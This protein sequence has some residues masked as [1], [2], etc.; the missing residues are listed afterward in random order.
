MNTLQLS[1]TNAK[2][3]TNDKL[4]QTF[5]NP[6]E[7]HG[8]ISLSNIALWYNWRNV[9]TKLGNTKLTYST[10]VSDASE[11]SEYEIIIPDGSYT[12]SGLN[13]YIH[14]VLEGAG[15][16]D[17]SKSKNDH[18]R[19][20]ISIYENAVYNGI[21]YKIK[22]GYGIVFGVDGL[23]MGLAKTLGG[24][25]N[26]QYQGTD[27]FPNVPQ[28]ENVKSVQIHCNLVYNEYQSDSSLLYNFTPNSTFGSLLSVEPRFPQW[29]QTR[30]TT[31][32]NIEVW[33]TDQDGKSLDVED[34]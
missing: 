32:N 33:L 25:E 13:Y 27:H 20:P 31:E 7:L 15:H 22:T 28:I 19:Y 12:V 5:R 30:N 14:H 17:A 1:T 29:R 2:T 24:V 10:P 9:T 34:D 6:M 18:D 11:T 4:R 23:S 16:V 3:E 8:Y 26:T 21:S